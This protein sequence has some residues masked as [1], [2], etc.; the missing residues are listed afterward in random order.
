MG[1]SNIELITPHLTAV[2]YGT[3]TLMP[4]VYDVKDFRNTFVLCD[5]TL[6]LFTG[7]EFRT[8]SQKVLDAQLL[9]NEKTLLIRKTD[10]GLYRLN[11]RKE[12]AKE[13]ELTTEETDLYGSSGD[14]KTVYF[15]TKNGDLYLYRKNGGPLLLSGENGVSAYVD[16]ATGRIT[17]S[18]SIAYREKNDRLFFVQD[19]ALYV[20]EK[21]GPAAAKDYGFEGDVTL[22]HCLRDLVQVTTFS[23]DVRRE[24][25]S[26]DGETFTLL[27]DEGAVN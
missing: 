7:E 1:G 11:G 16:N 18:G 9:D 12:N 25:L 19:Q 24:Y 13:E 8:I 20:S 4:D 23:G 27:T 3:G 6:Y 5:E 22:V 21:S 15:I 26:T 2:Q 17:H 10:G 14:G